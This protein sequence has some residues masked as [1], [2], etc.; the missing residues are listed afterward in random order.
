MA[1]KQLERSS[2]RKDEAS[3]VSEFVSVVIPMHNLTIK[4]IVNPT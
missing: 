2:S 1:C 4:L 3:G